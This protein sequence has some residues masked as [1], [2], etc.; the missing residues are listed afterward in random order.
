M[1]CDCVLSEAERTHEKE[2]LGISCA[3]SS[4][5]CLILSLNGLKGGV[6]RGGPSAVT[7]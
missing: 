6:K 1:Y 5:A 2:V 4:D 3:W 7:V